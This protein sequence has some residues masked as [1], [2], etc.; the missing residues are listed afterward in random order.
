MIEG[1]GGVCVAL[2]ILRLQ[3]C[4]EHRK[5]DFENDLQIQR[6]HVPGSSELSSCFL[7]IA[8]GVVGVAGGVSARRGGAIVRRWHRGRALLLLVAFLLAAFTLSLSI[9]PFLARRRTIPSS[10]LSSSVFFFRFESLS[11][12]FSM[13]LTVSLVVF[14]VVGFPVNVRRYSALG[15]LVLRLVLVISC[16]FEHR[17]AG[18]GFPTYRAAYRLGSEDSSITLP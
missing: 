16:R 1:A 6:T 3:T 4:V 13:K 7:G 2:K 9:R 11:A 15:V 8:R 12:S 14:G 18:G 10:G 5:H 17:S